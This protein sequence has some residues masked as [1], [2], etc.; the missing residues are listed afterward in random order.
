MEKMQ[1]KLHFLSVLESKNEE[2][3]DN[4]AESKVDLSAFEQLATK[5]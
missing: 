3:L 1:A 4:L 2:K 5:F